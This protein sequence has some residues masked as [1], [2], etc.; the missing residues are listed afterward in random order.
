MITT[1]HAQDSQISIQIANNLKSALEKSIPHQF[2]DEKNEESSTFSA[3]FTRESVTKEFAKNSLFSNCEHNR[4]AELRLITSDLSPIRG[5][6]PTDREPQPKTLQE[7]PISNIQRFAFIRTVK[8]MIIPKGAKTSQNF[9]VKKHSLATSPKPKDKLYLNQDANE[10][11]NEP[12]TLREAKTPTERHKKAKTIF[13]NVEENKEI[14][15]T[16]NIHKSK[17]ALQSPNEGEEKKLSDFRI[18]TSRHVRYRSALT[19]ISPLDLKTN[20]EAI[21]SPTI[22]TTKNDTRG[23]SRQLTNPYRK[24][25]PQASPNTCS[26][27]LGP[28]KTPTRLTCGHAFCKECIKQRLSVKIQEDKFPLC[29]PD[30]RCRKE[31]VTADV[32]RLVSLQD[33]KKF[34]GSLWKSNPIFG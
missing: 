32:W 8:A 7:T 9:H 2:Q 24:N 19:G 3:I 28:K 12:K 18:K 23:L 13:I 16:D 14:P 21:A 25:M 17:V 26:I 4:E 33:Y 5:N 31:V 11:C 15:K 27:C 30:I 34:E 22:M 10:E 6:S 1:Q 20:K 29:C